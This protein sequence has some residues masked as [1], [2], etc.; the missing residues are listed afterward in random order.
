MNSVILDIDAAH[1]AFEGHFP[2]RPILPAVVLL[3]EVLQAAPPADRGHE[4][5]WHIG[6]AK[7]LRSV[8]PGTRL[9]ITYTAH[10]AGALRFRILCGGDLVS[11]G[12]LLS[13]ALPHGTADAGSR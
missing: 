4:Q 10:S 13:S 3:D 7:F 6:A 9:Q 11:Q 2:G 12:T 5:G 1:P 8:R